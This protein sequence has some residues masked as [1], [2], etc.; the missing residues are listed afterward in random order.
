MHCF[1]D[2]TYTYHRICKDE[3]SVDC[4]RIWK[5][6]PVTDFK[7]IILASRNATKILTRMG[8][9]PVGIRTGYTLSTSPERYRYVNL[10]AKPTVYIEV[11]FILNCTYA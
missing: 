8:S 4:V 6:T 11:T 10:L 7:I 9:N 2:R 5:V 3:I 1:N